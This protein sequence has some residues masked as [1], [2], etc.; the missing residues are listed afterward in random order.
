MPL[1][2]KAATI[3]MHYNLQIKAMIG[4]FIQTKT[5]KN[6]MAKKKEDFLQNNINKNQIKNKI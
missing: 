3:A 2:M 1:L 4:I 5:I 6:K